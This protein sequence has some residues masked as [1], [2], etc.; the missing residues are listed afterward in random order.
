[1]SVG[2]NVLRPAPKILVC[3][4][5]FSKEN[6]GRISGNG[7]GR[8]VGSS[9][10]SVAAGWLTLCSDVILPKSSACR[11]AKATVVCGELVIL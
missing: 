10:S 3:H 1:M 9:F 8:R 5:G 2:R 7:G 4:G 6:G 11:F